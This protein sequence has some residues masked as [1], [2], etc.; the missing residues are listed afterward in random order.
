MKK[1]TFNPIKNELPILSRLIEKILDYIF[2]DFDEIEFTVAEQ[3]FQIENRYET[4]VVRIKSIRNDR[5]EDELISLSMKE[6]IDMNL[7]PKDVIG[8]K[9]FKFINNELKG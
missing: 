3:K 6:F 4:G 2:K 8:G 9:I 5:K 1:M 7:K